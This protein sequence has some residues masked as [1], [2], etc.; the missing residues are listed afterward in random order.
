MASDPY[1]LSEILA[2][3]NIHP[4]YVP[5]IKYPPEEETIKAVREQ[6]KRNGTKVDLSSQ[7]LLQ[8]KDLYRVIDRLVND[9][10]LQNTYRRSCY[11]S[12]TGGGSGGTPLFFATNVHENRRH[13]AQFGSFLRETGIVKETDWILTT[14]FV[15][16]LYRSMDLIAEICENAGATVLCGGPY[17]SKSEVAS[18]LSDYHVNVLAAESSQIINIV[19]YLSTLSHEERDRVHI[20]K[21]IYT[22]EMLTPAQRSFVKEVMGAVKIYSIYGSAEAGPW[23]VGNPEISQGQDFEPTEDFIFDTRSMI[24]EILDP[25]VVGS[26]SL[27]TSTTTL[28]PDGELGIIVQTSLHRLRNPLVRYITGD[29]GSIHPLPASARSK[30]PEA[31]WE[32]LRILRLYDRDPRFSFE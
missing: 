8:K 17:M 25:S 28:M 1:Q 10:S 12:T 15:G 14:H 20:E 5:D 4:F 31:D 7:S 30:I 26:G 32:F 29:L 3:A 16:H 21:I 13:R 2:I 19:Q 23:A 24:V 27:P 18:A 11:T 6:V 9:L 22:S